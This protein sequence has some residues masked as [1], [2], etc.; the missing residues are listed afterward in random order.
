MADLA[1]EG[2]VILPASPG[3]YAGAKDV[4]ELVDFIAAKVLDVVGVRHTL[5]RRWTGQ[6]ESRRNPPARSSE[7]SGV[8]ADSHGRRNPA[9]PYATIALA[10]TG[11]GHV[12][13]PLAFTTIQSDC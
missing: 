8:R 3:F 7:H 2:A 5:S 10:P 11:M 1:T 4:S 6:L 9:G 13:A 12:A